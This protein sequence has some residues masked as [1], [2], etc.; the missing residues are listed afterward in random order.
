MRKNSVIVEWLLTREL[1]RIEMVTRKNLDAEL[2]IRIDSKSGNQLEKIALKLDTSVG[3]IV[4]EAISQFVDQIEESLQE[5]KQNI[6]S[7]EVLQCHEILKEVLPNVE[8][9]KGLNDQLIKYG[10]EYYE[11]GGG[12]ALRWTTDKK[13]ICKASEVGPGYSRLIKKFNSPFP[14]HSAQW[15]ADRVLKLKKNSN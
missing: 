8:N 4:R 14:N 15:L 5:E 3:E 9:W 1:R 10:I 2:T 12:L 13:Y 7:N 11:R 6:K